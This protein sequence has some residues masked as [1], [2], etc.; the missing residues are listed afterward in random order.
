VLGDQA[1]TVVVTTGRAA[2]GRR[3]AVEELG[4]GVRVVGAGADGVDLAEALA[5][6]RGAGVRS[7]LVEGGARVITSFLAARLADRVVVGIAP[8]IVGAG[9]EAVGDL[10]IVRVANALRLENRSVHTAG[11][12]LL[13]AADVE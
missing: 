12:D 5:M 9:T 10:S 6:L 7:L 3:R 13:V 8:A 4:A 11:N 1:S 2:P